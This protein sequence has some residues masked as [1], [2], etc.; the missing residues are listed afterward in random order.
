MRASDLFR[1]ALSGIDL[2]TT[3]EVPV[4]REE[5]EGRVLVFDPAARVQALERPPHDRLWIIEAGVDEAQ[6]DVVELVAE[7]L[8]IQVVLGVVLKEGAVGDPG[9][10][11]YRAQI[12]A[13]DWRMGVGLG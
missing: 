3:F 12:C 11:L 13:D 2:Y 10:G 8:L 9:K 6:V 1:A 5:L 4:G 7:G